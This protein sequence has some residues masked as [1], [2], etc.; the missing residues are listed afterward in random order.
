MFFG[1]ILFLISLL[2]THYLTG[3]N[4]YLLSKKQNKIFFI[5][6][7][8]YNIVIMENFIT[9][10]VNEEVWSL[11]LLIILNSKIIKLVKIK[12]YFI[13]LS[14]IIITY[15]LLRYSFYMGWSPYRFLL[16]FLQLTL[17]QYF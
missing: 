5:L 9:F 4:F 10:E 11:I 17:C 6:I 14:F 15:I 1:L 12:L 16:S 7:I 3:K 8:A 13:M 2:L